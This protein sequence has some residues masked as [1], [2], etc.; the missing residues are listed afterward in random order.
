MRTKWNRA[1]TC[2]L[3]AVMI[4]GSIHLVA[5]DNN[6]GIEAPE[7]TLTLGQKDYDLKAGITY[8]EELYEDLQIDNDGGFDINKMDDYTVTYSLQ[9][10][11]A[12]VIGEEE[13]TSEI[14]TTPDSKQENN[15][16]SDKPDSSTGAD[17]SG[18]DVSDS[19]TGDT[20][21]SDSADTTGDDPADSGADSRNDAD[22]SDADVAIASYSEAG[23]AAQDAVQAEGGSDSIDKT[24]QDQTGDTPNSGE[25]S[26]AAK[27]SDQNDGETANG[28]TAAPEESTTPETPNENENASNQPNTALYANRKTFTR[29]VRVVEKQVLKLD[30]WPKANELTGDVVE[31]QFESRA[32]ITVGETITVSDGQILIVTGGVNLVDGKNT[33]FVVEDGG[34]LTLDGVNITG[35]T[36]GTQGAVCVQTGGQLDLG[37][38]G[39]TSTTVPQ[40][41]SNSTAAGEARNLVVADSAIVRLNARPYNPIGVSYAGEIAAPV[42]M[43]EGGRYAITEHDLKKIVADDAEELSTVLKLDHVLLRYAKPQFLHWD[44]TNWF[45]ANGHS[46]LGIY[47][48]RDFEEAGATVTNLTGTNANPA[49]IEAS[50]AKYDVIMLNAF[51][52]NMQ[53]A[54]GDG[55]KHDLDNEEYKLLEEF[56]NNGGRVILQ[57]ED[58]GGAFVNLNACASQIAQKLGA[59]YI[60]TNQP[61]GEYAMIGVSAQGRV[62]NTALTKGIQPFLVG[63]A[64]PI[65]VDAGTTS[66]TLFSGLATNGKWYPWA[67]DMPAGTRA[68]G[69]KWGNIMAISDGNFW[70]CKKTDA[71]PHLGSPDAI[72]FAKNILDNSCSNRLYAAL[73]YN[74][75]S[76][77]AQAQAEIGSTQYLTPAAALGKAKTGETVKLLA[78]QGLTPA[79]NELLFKDSSIQETNGNTVFAAINGTRIDVAGDGAITLR[80]GA[81]TVSNANTSASRTITVD[82]Y[83]LSATIDYTVKAVDPQNRTTDS[84]AS[85]TLKTR[86]T[87]LTATKGKE[88]YTYTATKDNQTFY[89][90]AF[91]TQLDWGKRTAADTTPQADAG[92][93]QSAADLVKASSPYYLLGNYVVTIKPNV[94]YTIKNADQIWVSMEDENGTP[95][96]LTKDN[97]FKVIKQHDGDVEVTVSKQITGDLRYYVGPVSETDTIKHDMT[98]LTINVAGDGLFTVTA[99]GE[100]YTPKSISSGANTFPVPKNEELKITF[101]PNPDKVKEPYYSTFTGEKGST[102]PFLTELTA[103]KGAQTKENPYN[104]SQNPDNGTFAEGVSFDWIEKAYT[105]KYKATEA[106]NTLDAKFELSHVFR[107][108]LTGGD[109]EVTKAGGDKSGLIH[110][111]HDETGDDAHH[112]IVKNGT[113]LKVS[114]TRRQGT[115]AGFFDAYWAVVQND[116]Q[117]IGTSLKGNSSLTGVGTDT[118]TYATPGITRPFILNATFEE[119]QPITIKVVN[120]TA[121]DGLPAGFAT[122]S[123]KDDGRLTLNWKAGA[124]DTYTTTAQYSKTIFAVVKPKTG[125]QIRSL[126]A[127]GIS[128]DAATAINKGYVVEHKNGDETYYI[129]RSKPI[130]RAWTATIEF[131]KESTVSFVNENGDTIGGPETV[132]QGGTISETLYEQVTAIIKKAETTTKKF[133]AWVDKT[134]KK[135]YTKLTQVFDSLILEPLFRT[136]GN[137]V[138]GEDGSITAADNI[139]VSK[140]VLQ[141]FTDGDAKV[142]ADVKAYDPEGKEISSADIEVEGLTALK[143][144]NTGIHKAALTFK[145]KDKNL[146]VSIDVEIVNSEMKIIG[147]TAHT[148]TFT[149]AGSKTY[150]VHLKGTQNKVTNAMTNTSGKAIA[151][152]LEKYTEYTIFHGD[153]GSVSGRTRLVDASDIARQFADDGDTTTLTGTGKAEAAK[154]KNVEV[155]V[156]E[157]GNYKVTLKK[158]I[159]HTVEVPDIWEDVTIDLNG[160]TIKG[161]D[162]DENSAA[163]PGLLFKK[164]ETAKRNPGTNLTVINGTIQGGSGSAAHPNG[165]PA[166]STAKAEDAT[167]APN[168]ASIDVGNG[169]KLLGGQGA[170]AVKNSGKDG[171]DGGSG[172]A[173]SIETYVNGGTV[174]GGDAGDGADADTEDGNPGNGGKGG[175][176]ISTSKNITINSGS[177]SG[178]KGG[179]GGKSLGENKKP[180]GAGGGGGN[181]TEGGGDNNNNGGNVSGG[182]GGD[183]GSSEKGDGGTGGAG[184]NTGITGGTGGTENGGNGGDGGQGQ[185][186]GAGGDGGTDSSGNN[187]GNAGKPGGSGSGNT[188]G[189]GSGSGSTGGG[190]TTKPGGSTSGGSTGGSTTKPGGTTTKPG[191]TTTKPG[192][193]TTKP[194]GNNNQG[195]NTKPGGNDNQGGNFGSN[196]NNGNNSGNHN[197]TNTGGNGSQGNGSGNGA[198]QN[199]GTSDGSGA[200]GIADG[201]NDGNGSDHINGDDAS[202]DNG[203]VPAGS[204]NVSDNTNGNMDAD[205]SADGSEVGFWQCSYHWSPIILMLVLAG[206]AVLRI[207]E[208]SSILKRKNQ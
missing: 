38:N 137:V 14:P 123:S 71:R 153:F 5:A 81:V 168:D 112:I 34:Q 96:M 174:K 73:G 124:D 179:K 191:D 36:V 49:K 69:T 31:I 145:V 86:G 192:G 180:G 130:T 46:D 39:S 143:Q 64:S 17:D 139:A 170:N 7:L 1:L 98:D 190:T 182:A 2:L 165:A 16:T 125:Y 75:N 183:G 110:R 133:F 159:D 200:N 62:E 156:D 72:T 103:D 18:N 33:L 63:A 201:N 142:R 20:S 172:I 108:F 195:G 89:L 4:I 155:S 83:T 189:S 138:V 68:D 44:T 184:G 162:A 202:Q 166:V 82:G 55:L 206:Y 93:Q 88:T 77:V 99:L 87:V 91:D 207:L 203:I 158:N 53:G 122:D 10:K 135:V 119:Q 70:A 105:V 74:P 24:Q 84:I 150:N 104:L 173:G 11:T 27:D 65:V 26:D 186:P 6:D 199:G 59:G 23:A 61:N 169:A 144:K 140:A 175:A 161:A 163:Q 50:F 40:I 151:E 37:D 126:T 167:G 107:V 188:G 185:K 79:S 193:T 157:N 35:N 177:V 187:N 116:T 41:S 154:N 47:Q 129:Y 164:D 19:N 25:E 131:A 102:F 181:A 148:L 198:N 205:G 15:S 147:R 204:D 21:N 115:D 8:N 176:G 3:V 128:I 152:G 30:H 43:M 132:L 134:T 67:V 101:K 149:G 196:D 76:L 80:S 194:G 109:V 90:G 160:R 141:G 48:A 29:V 58:A 78:N 111:G 94:N 51:Y 178:G 120:G 121:V 32:P 136:G 54:F 92:T 146:A 118:V 52:R 56:I 127:D 42:A 57:T 60:I 22:S 113:E 28:G 171:G 208:I 9:P 114:M 106:T 85:V 66:T 197:G 12:T 97:E 117:S 45:L 100:D 13:E 95:Q